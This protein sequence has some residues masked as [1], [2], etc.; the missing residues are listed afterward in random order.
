MI[1]VGLAGFAITIGLLNLLQ[2][3]TTELNVQQ[4][5]WAVIP[6]VVLLRGRSGSSWRAIR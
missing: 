5:T 6:A 1:T 3:G 4:L 2:L